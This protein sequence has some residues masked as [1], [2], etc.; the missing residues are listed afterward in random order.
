M[1]DLAASATVDVDAS[2]ALGAEVVAGARASARV[3]VTATATPAPPRGLERR[4]RLCDVTG[5]GIAE[6]AGATHGPITFELNRPA[7]FTLEMSLDDPAAVEVLAERFREVELWVGDWLV[8][9]GPIVATATDGR[10]LTL[11]G[12]DALWYL[13]HRLIGAP[14][15][16]RL[17]NPRFVDGTV[18]WNF[19]VSRPNFVLTGVGGDT[20]AE[21]TANAHEDE[22]RSLRLE[23]PNDYTHLF[24]FQELEVTAGPFGLEVALEAY[25]YAPA[26]SS[27]D[28]PDLGVE[29]V[30]FPVGYRGLALP[31][32][33]APVPPWGWGN[34]YWAWAL[35][36][37][38]R[39]AIARSSFGDDHPVDAWV[40]HR[41]TVRVAP[42]ATETI[43]ARVSGRV[44]AVYWA[45]TGLYLDEAL[46]F[47]ATDTAAIVAGLVDHAQDPALGQSNVNLTG[48]AT[49]TG[50]VVDR[51]Y[52]YAERTRV[53]EALA[54][55][56]KQGLLDYWLEVVPGRRTVA[57]ASPRRARAS[58]VVL[59]LG[60][61]IAEV[62]W[63]FDGDNAASVVAVLAAGSDTGPG[64]PEG[65]ASDTST[66]AGG[67]TL[68]TVLSA[69]ASTPAVR[70]NAVAEALLAT[71]VDPHTLAVTLTTAAS[72]GLV[73][74]LFP[75]DVV[76]V[77]VARAALVVD[78]DYRLV[79]ATLTPDNVLELV[80]NRET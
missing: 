38:A 34:L 70:L 66:F 8:T 23:Q 27:A 36:G 52:P 30:R 74:R 68:Q 25:A 55:L 9:A 33:G 7:A 39:K 73:G 41:C 49:P 63:A 51:R 48:P 64:Q 22:P 37:D 61:N 24:A 60:R 6:L 20:V 54:D 35:V 78:G 44:G 28:D 75:G 21:V 47:F 62:A 13:D 56:A 45:H 4:T 76:E 15:P 5:A 40:R 10:R 58:R 59:E 12:A 26:S 31:I 65:H 2:V 43:H 3:E 71:T 50:V 42:N 57:V 53:L 11:T 29:F 46:E 18:G 1:T 69:P 19:L 16:N 14:V 77:R 17:A 72:A 80:L 32:S 79:R 67:L